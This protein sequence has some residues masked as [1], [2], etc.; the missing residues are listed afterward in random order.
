MAEIRKITFVASECQPFI[1]SGGLG[2]VIGSL[3]KAI[4]KAKKNYEVSVIVPCYSKIDKKV[5][6]KMEFVAQTTVALAWR[7]QYCGIYKYEKHGVT[8]YFLEYKH[9]KITNVQ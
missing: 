6:D 2:D 3:P 5:K 7:K 4:A 9:H 8:F 1:A